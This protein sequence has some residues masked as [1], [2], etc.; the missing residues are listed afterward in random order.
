MGAVTLGN[1]V[2]SLVTA[3]T[4]EVTRGI[5]VSAGTDSPSDIVPA[6]RFW[7]PWF[8]DPA[9]GA[10]VDKTYNGDAAKVG[11]GVATQTRGYFT[12]KAGTFGTSG[13]GAC[14]EIEAARGNFELDTQTA[15]YHATINMAA[16]GSTQYPFGTQYNTSSPGTLVAATAAG[17]LKLYFRVGVGGTQNG[18]ALI[19][20]MLD[21]KDH[22]LTLVFDRNT[23][24]CYIFA[25]GVLFQTLAI[26]GSGTTDS[27]APLRIGG[28]ASGGNYDV[29]FS[30]MH[31]YVFEADAADLNVNALV[32][33]LVLQRQPLLRSDV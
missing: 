17:E 11:L 33:K 22:D 14:Y 6:A 24:N 26:S 28:Y 18:S 31:L 3:E 23:R 4:N 2:K 10:A 19:P 32:D 20:G 25:D 21:S 15:I 16:P 5:K 30:N 13:T 12:S 9:S 1:G 7:L 29:K 8:R 27:G